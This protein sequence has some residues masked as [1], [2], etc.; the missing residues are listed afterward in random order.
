VGRDFDV[1]EADHMPYLQLV[2]LRIVASLKRVPMVITW[3]EVWGKDGWRSYIGRLGFAAALIERFCIRLPDS[4]VA[5]STGT[6][7]KLERMGAKCGRVRV[8]PNALDLDELLGTVARPSAPELLFVG[9]LLDHK[10]PD[11]A[12]EATKILA[13]RGISVRLGIIGVG[14]EESRLRTQVAESNLESQVSFYSTI[15]SQRDLWSMIRGSQ[16]LLAPSIREGSGLVV[17]ESLALG[18]PVVCAVHPENESSKL[19]GVETGSLV[20]ALDAQ[21]IADAAE[22]WLND[23]SSRDHRASVFLA[24]NRGLAAAAMASSYAQI[25]RGLA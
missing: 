16:V 7:E 10:H 25:F 4:I 22:Y 12:V 17:A 14:P 2:P 13:T 18:T 8:V 23:K 20:P 6:A 24:G 15:D 11:L 3:H 19:I 1:I 21:A 9:R 5:V